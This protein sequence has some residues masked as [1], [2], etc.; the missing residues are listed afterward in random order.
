M[1]KS[2]HTL[3]PLATLALLAG[4]AGM[5]PP[6]AEK[7]AALPLVTYPDTPP[8]G[9]YVYLL[10]AGKP[11]QMRLRADGTALAAPVDQS[12][13]AALGRDLYLHRQWASEDGR[14]W[15]PAEQLVGVNLTVFLPSYERP[16]PGDIHL[17]V[18][19][20]AGGETR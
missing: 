7:L 16:G 9:D 6:P 4:C 12:V 11:I 15:L 5:T 13:D 18:D 19:R 1:K 10:P 20:K 17:T 3:A 14:H 2:F 8:A